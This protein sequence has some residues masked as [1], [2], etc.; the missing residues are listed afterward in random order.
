MKAKEEMTSQELEKDTIKPTMKQ[1]ISIGILLVIVCCLFVIVCYWDDS[2]VKK[3]SVLE[4][5]TTNDEIIWSLGEIS[6][7]KLITIKGAYAYIPEEKIEIYNTRVYL[8]DIE[9]N[10]FYEV[11]SKQLPRKIETYSTLEL[12]EVKK[13]SYERGY[14]ES[15]FYSD[16]IDLDNKSYEIVLFYGNNNREDYIFTD[17]TINQEGVVY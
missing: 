1:V 9:N 6:V 13:Y 12:E 16:K 10:E 15:Y 11:P 14:F 7:D 3:V 17:I 5:K 4:T 8:R 2:R